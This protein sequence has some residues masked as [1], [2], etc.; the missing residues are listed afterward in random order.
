[1]LGVILPELVWS[2]RTLLPGTRA[3]A[4]IPFPVLVEFLLLQY[5]RLLTIRNHYGFVDSLAQLLE[6]SLDRSLQPLLLFPI[7]LGLHILGN[8][9]P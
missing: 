7:L 6:R 8:D 9:I 2:S 5:L 3:R 4:P 1:M